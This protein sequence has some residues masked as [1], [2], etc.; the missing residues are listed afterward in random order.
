MLAR[1]CTNDLRTKFFLLIV[2][3]YFLTQEVLDVVLS[4]QKELLDNEKLH[5]TLSI[6]DHNQV[7]FYI[8]VK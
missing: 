7:H 1:K 2:Q 3:D 5:E 6:S 8:K 4:S